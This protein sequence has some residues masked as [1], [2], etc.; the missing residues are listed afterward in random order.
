MLTIKIVHAA[1][2]TM[3]KWY[4]FKNS[5]VFSYPDFWD[6]LQNVPAYQIPTQIK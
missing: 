1:L 5:A 4:S 2:S 3:K 6:W